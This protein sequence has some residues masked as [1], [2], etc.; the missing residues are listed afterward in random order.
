M[1]DCRHCLSSKH[2][3][4][5]QNSFLVS[6]ISFVDTY[7]KEA[8]KLTLSKLEF[9][10]ENERVFA[11]SERKTN[12]YS[13]TGFKSSKQ[14]HV[15]AS[16]KFIQTFVRLGFSKDYFENIILVTCGANGLKQARITKK[17]NKSKT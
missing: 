14:S 4:C 13:V 2:C 12:T 7:L 1:C 6:F 10:P 5:K 11:R 8:I 15:V 3:V 16:G 9:A 17:L